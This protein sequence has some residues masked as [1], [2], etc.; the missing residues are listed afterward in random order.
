MDNYT[1][2]HLAI[3][4]AA[5]I[6]VNFQQAMRDENFWQAADDAQMLADIA[7]D[8]LGQAVTAKEQEAN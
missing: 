8:M 7:R 2:Q 5:K 6:I 1:E 3:G 4:K